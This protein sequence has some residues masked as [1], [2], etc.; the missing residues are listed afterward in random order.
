MGYECKKKG[1]SFRYKFGVHEHVLRYGCGWYSFGRVFPSIL[2]S[3]KKERAR[4][5]K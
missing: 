2:L 1:Q 3:A 4:N 5:F